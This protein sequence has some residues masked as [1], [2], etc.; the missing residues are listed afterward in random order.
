MI[1]TNTLAAIPISPVSPSLSISPI[2]LSKCSESELGLFLSQ[3]MEL[4][5][6]G[7]FDRLFAQYFP[8]TGY[9]GAYV[10]PPSDRWRVFKDSAKVRFS[11]QVMNCFTISNKFFVGQNTGTSKEDELCHVYYRCP[12]RLRS[13]AVN[14][15]NISN[16]IFIFLKKH[17]HFTRMWPWLDLYE[18]QS[19][20]LVPPELPPIL[21]TSCLNYTANSVR[22]VK[23]EVTNMP[24]GTQ[25]KLSK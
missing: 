19:D 25:K 14:Q 10:L 24:C 8:H 3:R 16:D 11:C 23:M 4:V 1:M 15:L 2:D 17:V 21:V 5:W 6:H 18:R 9:S 7:E 12:I 20:L 22:N 13:K